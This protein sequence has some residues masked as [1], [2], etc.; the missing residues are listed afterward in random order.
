MIYNNIIKKS[1]H[2]S[3]FSRKVSAGCKLFPRLRRG[4]GGQVNSLALVKK[5]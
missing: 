3:D 5:N 4:F 1:Y 2:T